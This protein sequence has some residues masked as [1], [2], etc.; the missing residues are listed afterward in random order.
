MQKSTEQNS[1]HSLHEQGCHIKARNR[2]QDLDLEEEHK[3]R[4]VGVRSNERRRRLHEEKGEE[5]GCEA[6][7]TFHTL[8]S[9][10]HQMANN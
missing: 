6:K 8:V 2:A 9:S 10:N 7:R 3:K 4:Q 5:D 1:G